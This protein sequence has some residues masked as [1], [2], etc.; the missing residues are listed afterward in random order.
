MFTAY[1]NKGKSKGKPSNVQ[2]YR[3]GTDYI[4][5]RFVRSEIIYRYSYLKT[6]KLHVEKMKRLA[7]TGEGLNAYIMKNARK[8]G[9]FDKIY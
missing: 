7:I 8:Q 9:L 4:D 5:V 6:G 1:L 3:L 2:E